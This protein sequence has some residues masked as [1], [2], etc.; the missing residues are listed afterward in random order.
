MASNSIQPAVDSKPH[1]GIKATCGAK[2]RAGHPCRRE[3]GWNTDHLGQGRCRYHGGATPIKHGRYSKITRPRIQ[4]LITTHAADPDPLDTMPELAAARALFQD[5]IERY[6]ENT[7]ALLA[8]HRSWKGSAFPLGPEKA[9]ALIRVLDEYE[10]TMAGRDGLS[11]TQEQDLKLA[12]E[13]VAIL[14][15]AP[16]EKPAQV[17]DISDAYRIVSEI[18]KI[19]ERVQKA[20]AANAISHAQLRTFL[21]A[22]ERVINTRIHDPKLLETLR[23][24]ILS[25]RV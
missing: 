15:Q 8:W 6:D 22:L 13:A 3:A 25:I 10:E 19:V 2:T 1:R 7:E 24:D 4:E 9:E 11:E 16:A 20:E 17:L 21:F 18:T 23:N 12:R 5:F 14:Q